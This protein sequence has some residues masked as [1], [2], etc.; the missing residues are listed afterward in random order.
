M[1]RKLNQY[2]SIWWREAKD[3][4]TFGRVEVT[5]D[6]VKDVA[7]VNLTRIIKHHRGFF[8]VKIPKVSLLEEAFGII[9]PRDVLYATPG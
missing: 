6:L 1:S 5:L 4:H 7:N 8:V 2:V 9:D 3:L